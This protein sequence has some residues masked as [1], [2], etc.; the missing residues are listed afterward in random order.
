MNRIVDQ[1]KVNSQPI[2]F[3]RYVDNCFALFSKQ[4]EIL[5]FYQQLYKIHLDIR[6]INE[7]AKNY[8]ISFLDVWIDI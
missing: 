3:Y 4:D 7:I 1:T 6:L 2:Q 8:Q 5:N